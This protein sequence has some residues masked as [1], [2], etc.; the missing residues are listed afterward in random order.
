M[1]IKIGTQLEEEVYQDLKIAA[2]RERRAIGEVIQAAVADYLKRQ[3]TPRGK[4]S[5]LA[6]LLEA[7]PLR[8]TSEQIRES[9]ESDF[10]DQ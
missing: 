1:K 10:F 2:A 7:D 9:M 5:G 8:L 3:A 6:R 4:K